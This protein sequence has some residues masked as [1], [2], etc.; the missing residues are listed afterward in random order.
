MFHDQTL[1]MLTTDNN[2]TSLKILLS[3]LLLVLFGPQSRLN[4]LFMSNEVKHTLRD[5]ITLEVFGTDLKALSQLVTMAK[6]LDQH[7]SVAL[8]SKQNFSPQLLIQFHRQT[9]LIIL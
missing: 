3:K 4:G 5:N 2:H 1:Y 8:Q 9:S 6:C 7:L